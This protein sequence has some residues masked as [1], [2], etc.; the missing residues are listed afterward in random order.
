MVVVLEIIA[1]TNEL[2]AK[3]RVFDLDLISQ[4]GVC[5]SELINIHLLSLLEKIQIESR[6]Y[7]VHVTDPLNYDKLTL[8]ALPH[9]FVGEPPLP[10]DLRIADHLIDQTLSCLLVEFVKLQSQGLYEISRIFHDSRI[11]N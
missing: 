6:N 11:A 10:K 4:S 9:Q 8:L 2:I 7:L 5:S 1:L 3:R